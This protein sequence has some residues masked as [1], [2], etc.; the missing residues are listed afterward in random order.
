MVRLS[1]LTAIQAYGVMKPSSRS[2]PDMLALKA[3]ICPRVTQTFPPE[4][5]A[6][7]GR[8]CSRLCALSA[9]VPSPVHTLS[10]FPKN[11]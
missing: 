2:P 6:V 10:F 7:F 11:K 4:R 9:A 1:Y 5:R 8:N 3:T